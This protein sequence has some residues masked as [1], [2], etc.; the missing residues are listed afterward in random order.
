MRERNEVVG[1]RLRK[2]ERKIREKNGKEGLVI[3][4]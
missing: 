3:G 4:Y 2:R 1:D